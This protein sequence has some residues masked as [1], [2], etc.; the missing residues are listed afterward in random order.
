VIHKS[1]VLLLPGSPGALHLHLGCA[2]ILA[3][4]FDCGRA[5]VLLQAMHLPRA[6]G[7]HDPGPLREQPGE[8]D[9]GRRCILAGRDPA[10]QIDERLVGL[11]E[12]GKPASN[13]GFFERRSGIEL[14]REEA[15][16]KRT[17]GN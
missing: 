17:P 1:R 10:Q 11:R 12:T 2:E 3:C 7:R 16:A 13:V 8:L 14:A 5:K 15:L 6:G 4:E 9:L